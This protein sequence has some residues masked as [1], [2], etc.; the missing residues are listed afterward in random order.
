MGRRLLLTVVVLA[1]ASCAPAADWGGTV[2]E[3]RHEGLACG[4]CHAGADV[5]DRVPSVPAATCSSAGCHEAE[6]PQTVTMATVEFEHRG[7][8]S[9]EDLPMGC[10]GCHTHEEGQDELVADTGSCALCHS[11]E[12]TGANTADC[13]SCHVGD[14]VGATS[15]GVTVPHEGL[16]WISGGCV[17]CHYDVAPPRAE[18]SMASCAACHVE[19]EAELRDALQEDLHPSHVQVTCTSCHDQDSHQIVAMSSAVRLECGDCHV[20]FHQ[21]V[22]L[23]EPFEEETCNACHEAVHAEQQAMVLGLVDHDVERAASE[24]FMDGLTCRSC[25]LPDEAATDPVRGSGAGC[26]SCHRPEY[27]TVLEWWKEGVE[28]RTD[29][30]DAD[31]RG[32]GQRIADGPA[33]TS[34]TEA[35]EML[36][37]IREASGVHNLRLTH[38]LLVEASDRI[39]QAYDEAGLTPPPRPSLGNEPT[40]GVCNYCHYRLG[41]TQLSTQ[42]DTVFH[43][44][45]MGVGR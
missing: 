13:R 17:R 37:T 32:A 3:G 22:T 23:D 27:A 35:R 24:K 45:V 21:L 39:G 25:H 4:D 42:M 5:G 18:V 10:A 2:A 31:L 20:E 7:H 44:E 28:A 12:L 15:Q 6:G 41:A 30:V 9:T 36:T 16:P 38:R 19:P 34:L 29:R 26:A 8:A 11:E 33:R 43:R 14:P 40:M 1:C